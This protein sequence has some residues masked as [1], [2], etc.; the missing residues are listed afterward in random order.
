MVGHGDYPGSIRADQPSFPGAAGQCEGLEPA[1]AQR[2]LVRARA[3]LQVAGPARAVRGLAHGL[4]ADEPLVQE[5]GAGP[6]VRGPTGRGHRQRE[7]GG[8]VAGQHHRQGP[9]RRDRGLEKRGP[10]PSG[11][12]G[13]DG[14]PRFIWLPRM[15][16]RR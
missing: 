15:L 5:R 14:R 7:A 10:R 8:R 13:A 12:P 3:R 1:G 16:E 9:S 2:G 6:G 11:S 4:H